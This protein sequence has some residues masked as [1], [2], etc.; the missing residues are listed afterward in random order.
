MTFLVM[1]RVAGL[2]M[3]AAHTIL[4]RKPPQNRYCVIENANL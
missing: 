3:G 1:F 4:R 2:G